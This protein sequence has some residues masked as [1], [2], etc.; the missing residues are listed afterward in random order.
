MARLAA[1]IDPLTPQ[2]AQ[3]LAE[4]PTWECQIETMAV[5]SPHGVAL[6]QGVAS[7]QLVEVRVNVRPAAE[8][9]QGTGGLEKP[10]FTLSRWVALTDEMSTGGASGGRFDRRF[11]RQPASASVR[12]ESEAV[13]HPADP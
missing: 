7:P 12:S 11:D 3:P 9:G 10:W 13:F 5:A 8:N 6:P 2:E 1:G 4:D